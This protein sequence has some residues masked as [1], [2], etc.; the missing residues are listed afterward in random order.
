MALSFS[1]KTLQ[2]Y[3]LSKD[4]GREHHGD[5]R[6]E[7]WTKKSLRIYVQWEKFTKKLVMTF[8]NES[9]LKTIWVKW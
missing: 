7:K 2:K 4:I 5:S 6:K 9:T 1:I 8:L 3:Y